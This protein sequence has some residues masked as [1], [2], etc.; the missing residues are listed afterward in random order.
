MCERETESWSRSEL[1]R[2]GLSSSCLSVCL[3]C[4]ITFPPPPAACVSGVPLTSCLS[5]APSPLPVPLSFLS[6]GLTSGASRLYV[7]LCGWLPF[8]LSPSLCSLAL[9]VLLATRSLA[10]RFCCALALCLSGESLALSLCLSI[11]S[12]RPPSPAPFPCLCLLCLSLSLLVPFI[13]RLCICL[14]HS[15]WVSLVPRLCGSLAVHPCLCVCL[16]LPLPSP[17]FFSVSNTHTHIYL[18]SNC[19]CLGWTGLVVGGRM[20]GAVV[21]GGLGGTEVAWWS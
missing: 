4:I 2:P 21:L 7:L 8:S 6:L 19:F 14:S 15:L 1:G 16:S 10:F 18:R 9:P 17:P 12:S 5:L 3:S 11:G 20:G 13:S